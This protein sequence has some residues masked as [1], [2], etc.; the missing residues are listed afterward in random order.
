M[1]TAEKEVAVSEFIKRHPS[2][3]VKNTHE[4]DALAAALKA[5]G[6]FQEKLD[7]LSYK[8]REMGF[9]DVNLQKYKVKV[10]MNEDL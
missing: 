6:E 10:L 9:Y 1:S 4:R 3:D 7:K 2:I 5:Y 8:L